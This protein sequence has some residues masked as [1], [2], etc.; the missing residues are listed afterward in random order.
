MVKCRVSSNADINLFI[1]L[2]S[3]PVI[4]VMESMLCRWVFSFAGLLLLSGCGNAQPTGERLATVSASGVLT[5]NSKPLEYYQVLFFP[6]NGQRPAAG[7]ADA[8]GKFV[9]GT[10]EPQDGAVVGS[11]KVA[12]NWVGP[13]STDPNDGIMEFSE[14]PA[15]SIRIDPRYSDPETSGLVVEIPASGTNEIRIDLK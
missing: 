3:C 6:P 9:L 15:P 14:P 10:N 8:E 4:K 7:T 12:I 13:P 5:L 11:H 2:F 1:L